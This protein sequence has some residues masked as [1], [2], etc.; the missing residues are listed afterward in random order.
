M[1]R[2]AVGVINGIDIGMSIKQ[3]LDTLQ[4]A[5]SRGQKERRVA[6]LIRG[7]SIGSSIKQELDTLTLPANRGEM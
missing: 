3:Q 1:E 6:V 4:L 2:R 7:I 5:F